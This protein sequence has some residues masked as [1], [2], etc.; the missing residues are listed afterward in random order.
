MYVLCRFLMTKSLLKFQLES[1]VFFMF[2]DTFLPEI[3]MYKMYILKSGIYIRHL[4][5]LTKLIMM[6]TI[7]ID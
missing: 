6:I 7:K 1:F 3:P 5:P 4:H 2:L